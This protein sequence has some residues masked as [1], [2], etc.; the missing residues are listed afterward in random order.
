[1]KKK[2]D[3]YAIGNA[4]VDIVCDVQPEFF[5]QHQVEKGLM[6]LVD[7]PRQDYLVNVLHIEEKNMQGGGSAANTIVASSQFGAKCFYSCKVSADSTGQFFLK[8]LTEAGI[9]TNFIDQVPPEGVTGKCLVMTTPDADRT[10]NT[11]LGISATL[12]PEQINEQ[13]I[14]DAQYVYIEGYMVASPDSQPAMVKVREL[15]KKHDVKVALTFSDPNMVKF[16]KPGLEATIGDGI[17]LLFCNED[18]ALTWAETDDLLVAREALKHV[19]KQFVITLG[20]NGATIFDGDTFIDIEPYK[21]DAI[22]T[23]GAGDMYAGAFLYGVTHGH[24]LAQAGKI[25]SLAS[26]KVVAK[27]GPRLAWHQAKEVLN[28]LADN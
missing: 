9:D 5:E 4:L 16:F 15:A 17:D 26:S 14:A 13:A 19:A 20:A 12:S 1:M 6:T 7:E 28:H 23:N 21:V 11:F 18:E 24:T 27:V 25:A 22:D 10:M 3:I 2:Y 8:D